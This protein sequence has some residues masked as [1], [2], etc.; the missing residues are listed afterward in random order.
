MKNSARYYHKLG[1][2]SMWSAWHLCPILTKPEFS[3][4]ILVKS[5]NTKFHNKKVQWEPSFLMRTDVTTKVNSRFSQRQERV[6]NRVHSWRGLHSN[7]RPSVGVIPEPAGPTAT[8]GWFTS[9]Y[10]TGVHFKDN[11]NHLFHRYTVPM[12]MVFNVKIGY[13]Q[14]NLYAVS[15]RYNTGYDMVFSVVNPRG[16][17]L[18]IGDSQLQPDRSANS[19]HPMQPTCLPFIGCSKTSSMFWHANVYTETTQLMCINKILRRCRGPG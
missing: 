3:W 7:P 1:Y 19:G 16:W 15:V 12:T 4:Q 17:S 9:Y 10:Q 8:A 2:V 14:Y 11:W 5:L 18:C 6:Q 13:N